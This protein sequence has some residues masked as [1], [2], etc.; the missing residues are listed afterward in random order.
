L[1]TFDKATILPALLQSSKLAEYAIQL[2]QA[3][4]EVSR[5]KQLLFVSCVFRFLT[6]ASTAGLP[7]SA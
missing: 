7:T 1:Q 4:D 6:A 3:F 5:T 2:R